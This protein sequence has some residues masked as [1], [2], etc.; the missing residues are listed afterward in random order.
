MTNTLRTPV[1][2]TL[3]LAVFRVHIENGLS[4]ALGVGLTGLAVG[5]ALGFAAA[6]AAATGAVAVSISDQPDPLRQKPW[7]LGF[8]LALAIFFTA[9]ASFAGFYPVSLIAATA[10]TGFF[11]GLIS[12]YGKRALSLSMT[13]VLAFVFAMGQHLVTPAQAAVHL[14]YTVIGVVLYTAY[15]GL[16]A[17]AFDDR[18]RRLL[19]AEAMRGFATYLRA[20]AALYNPDAEGTAA[21]HALIDAHAALVDRL[22]TARDALFARRNHPTQL[23]RIDTLIALLDAFETMLSSDA[24]VELLRRSG[25]REIKWRISALVLH[26]A[27]EV[28]GLTLALRRRHAD[29]TPRSHEEECEALIAAVREA[30]DNAPEGSAVDHA[31]TVSAAKLRLADTNVAALAMTLNRDT[32]PSSLAAELDLDAFRAP[33]PHGIDVLLR[34]FDLKAPAMR[35][36][37]RLALAMTAGL[38]LTLLFPRFA[39]ANWV[40]LT[41]A[42]IMRAN[43]SVTSQR[44]W[45]RVTG[46]LIGCTLAVVFLM[47]FPPTL[48]LTAIV[49]AVGV[50]HAYGLVKYR[51]TAIS[52]SVSSLL[53]LHFSAPLDH[54]QFFERIVD[55]LIGA[56]LSWAFSFVLPYWESNTLPRIVRGLLA[57]DS[58]FANVA[59]RLAPPPQ[60][61]RLARKKAMDAVAL[62]SGAIR[63]LADEPNI[64]RRALAALTELLG[65]NYLFASDLASMPVLMKL[66]GAELDQDAGDEIEAVRLRII[67]LLSPDTVHKEEEQAP[68]REGLSALKQSVAMELLA[69]RLAHIEHAAGKVARLAVRPIIEG[70]L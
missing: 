68:P 45:D 9:L 60:A 24:D 46:T 2:R 57:A 39:H 47:I 41:I 54:P 3:A 33:S 23:K 38:G 6:I 51:V 7:I 14:A 25:R 50:S 70:G 4:V 40:L 64:N 11:T 10:F 44:R 67:A 43:Y 49:L 31:F 55:T 66:R 53:L 5:W 30:N 15:A 37:I 42:L 58:G 35:Y 29:V 59:L 16:F 62:M 18:V 13:A 21:F 17:W 34:Q 20:K 1:S 28:D 8:A 12:A 48:L 26:I 65:A 69:R 52:A 32:P 63:R 56:G 27:E 36:G 22:Q 19:L 61:Y